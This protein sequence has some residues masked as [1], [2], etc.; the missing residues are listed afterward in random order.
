MLTNPFLP[1]TWP[2]LVATFPTGL[3]TIPCVSR[4]CQPLEYAVIGTFSIVRA[5]DT[6]ARS[7]NAC[8][9]GTND[10]A[11]ISSHPFCAERIGLTT[12]CLRRRV[13]RRRELPSTAHHG[14]PCGGGDGSLRSDARVAFGPGGFLPSSRRAR[15][16]RHGRPSTSRGWR[17][18]SDR[19]GPVPPDFTFSPLWSSRI[20]HERTAA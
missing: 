17:P 4:P 1:T 10:A 16:G 18:A 9:G 11:P 2:R 13:C 12:R 20:A 19:M 8:P 6:G 3:L 7:L 14:R 15:R 5:A